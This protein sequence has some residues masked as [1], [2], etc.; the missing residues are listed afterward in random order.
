[1]SI[2]SRKDLKD[3]LLKRTEES[4]TTKDSSGQFGSIF[5]T[6]GPT[7]NM[8]KIVEGDHTIDILPFVVGE[9]YPTRN[10]PNVKKGDLAYVLDVW[11]H[12]KVGP[13]QD[14]IV[15]PSRNYDKPCP[16]CEQINELRK[17][18]EEEDT[19]K[20]LLPKRRA[21]YN[22]V[23]YDTPKEEAKGIQ[24]MDAS[25]FLL[26]HRIIELA[27]RPQGGGM[28][29]FADPD[30]GKQIFFRRKGTGATNTEF[31]AYQFIDRD[32]I[33]SD[34]TLEQTFSLDDLLTV[35]SYE[36]I[37]DLFWGTTREAISEPVPAEVIKPASVRQP[38]P[39]ST[40]KPEADKKPNEPQ[41]PGATATACPG[42]GVFGVDTDNLEK[43]GLCDLW[44][45]CAKRAD[46]IAE[47]AKAKV[48][49]E[50]PTRRRRPV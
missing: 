15:C 43:C 41:T 5:K 8:F 1:M 35:K 49:P 14:A 34:E 13:N 11:V 19:I 3:Q 36:E 21:V 50:E 29:P 26:E 17:S 44:D 4:H 24:I 47:E 25:H 30:D 7:L 20:A 31:T 42:G 27:R 10:Y 32:Y 46:E 18:D 6:D 2:R 40:H 38:K 9:N 48:Q 22:V 45:D 28:I 33:I 37:H 39:A 16:V 23:S 12:Y